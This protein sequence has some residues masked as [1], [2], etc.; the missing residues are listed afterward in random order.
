MV[1]CGKLRCYFGSKYKREKERKK[2]KTIKIKVSYR[3]YIV[4]ARSGL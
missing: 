4:I 3:F 1:L 2:H